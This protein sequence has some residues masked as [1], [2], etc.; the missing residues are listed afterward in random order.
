MSLRRLVLRDFVIVPAL[1]V[2][3]EAGFTALTGETGA[4]KSILIDALQLALGARGDA[5]WIREGALRCEISAEFDAPPLASPAAQWCLEQGFD[6]EGDALLVR[7]AIDRAGKSRAWINGSPATVAQLRALGEWLV[8]IYGQHAWQALTRPASVRDLLDAYGHIDT[9]P[10]TAAWHIWQTAVQTLEQARAAQ[11]RLGEQRERLLWQIGETEKL[12]PGEGEWEEINLRHARL[13]NAQ[14]LIDAAQAATQAIEGGEDGESS[15]T[16]P[17]L[18]QATS[19]LAAQQTIEP[20]FAE[21]INTL[22]SC[23][24]QLRDVGHG[25]RAYLSRA[26][27]DPEQLAALDERLNDKAY[28]VPGLGDAGDRL[29]GVV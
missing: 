25:L 16:L 22:E 2:T 5:I 8:D 17:L 19:A 20:E 28:I 29:Y 3:L 18:A 7:R 9:V 14:A 26:E 4:G 23:A 24:V 27:T 12:A 15:G 10:L 21:A 13:S 11:Q 1:D 6:A